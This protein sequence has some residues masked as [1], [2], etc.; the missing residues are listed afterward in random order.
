[1][2]HTIKNKHWGKKK[3]LGHGH[4]APVKVLPKVGLW[5]WA[6]MVV[7]VGFIVFLV[8]GANVDTEERSRAIYT[9]I[10]EVR[11]EVGLSNLRWSDYLYNKALAHS[12]Y[13]GSSGQFVH[14][15]YGYF[16][17][18]CKGCGGNAVGVWL[19]SPLHKQILLNPSITQCAVGVSGQYA[20]FMAE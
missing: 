15:N 11:A 14:S 6:V 1:M 4:V 8:I 3:F 5:Q 20:T 12:Q 2:K 7:V 9:D 10:N 17:T 18:I 16:E 13:M 19:D